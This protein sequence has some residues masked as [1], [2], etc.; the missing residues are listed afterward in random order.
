MPKDLKTTH[1]LI[2]YVTKAL[3]TLV[4]PPGFKGTYSLASCGAAIFVAKRPPPL[5]SLAP[6][7]ICRRGYIKGMFFWGRPYVKSS[8][9]MFLSLPFFSGERNVQ[10]A[11]AESMKRCGMAQKRKKK[12][13]KESRMTC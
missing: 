8:D 2:V 3:R 6:G 5:P 7:C 1:C 10:A 11:V 13:L 9:A 12:N 4:F